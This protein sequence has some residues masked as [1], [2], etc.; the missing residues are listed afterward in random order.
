[1]RVV[2]GAKRLSKSAAV[3]GGFGSSKTETRCF[4]PEPPLAFTDD[5][6]SI[7]LARLCL[8][9]G[10]DSGSL[11]RKARRPRPSSPAGDSTMARDPNAPP[12]SEDEQFRE[13]ARLLGV[14]LH[15]WHRLNQTQV[16]K[17][18]RVAGEGAAAQRCCTTSEEVVRSAA[19]SYQA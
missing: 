17:Y 7:P 16:G 15:R 8:Q 5:S 10:A 13:V 2:Q 19:S 3:N 6:E 18:V 14:A 1:M 11:E 12:A 9:E 4:G